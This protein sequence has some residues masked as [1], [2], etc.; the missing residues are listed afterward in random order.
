MQKQAISVD[1]MR[2]HIAQLTSGFP[3]DADV[4]ISRVKRLHQAKVLTD[5][6]GDVLEMWLPTVRSVVSYAVALHEVGHMKSRS[7]NEMVRERAAWQWAKDNALV[8]TPQMERRAAE[9]L[10]WIETTATRA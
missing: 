10:A 6:Y 4:R 2:R 5:D 9:A 8:W 7:R 3:P 1:A